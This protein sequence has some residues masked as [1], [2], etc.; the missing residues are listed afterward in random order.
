MMTRHDSKRSVRPKQSKR[1]SLYP[2]AGSITKPLFSS[3]IGGC[4]KLVDSTGGDGK[5]KLPSSAQLY[6]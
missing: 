5:T 3:Q 6:S 1:R 4:W 2:T